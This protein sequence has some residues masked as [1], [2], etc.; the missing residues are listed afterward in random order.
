MS[1][2]FQNP[3]FLMRLKDI[4]QR[5]LQSVF[6]HRLE[7]CL[8]KMSKNCLCE[9]SYKPLYEMSFRQPCKI[10]SR[11]ANPTFFR[12]LKDIL[13]RCLKCPHKTSLRHLQDIFL[14]TETIFFVIRFDWKIKCKNKNNY[15]ST[16]KMHN[17]A[18]LRI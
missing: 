8:A 7:N 5:C 11:F 12:H 13:L 2:R 16:N 10:S 1:S 15:T 14:Q 4:L 6:C 3:T 18:S 17:Y 9:M